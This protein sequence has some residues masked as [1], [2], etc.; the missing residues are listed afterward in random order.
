MTIRRIK[1]A[2]PEMTIVTDVALDRISDGHDGIV[3]EN[4]RILNDETVSFGPQASLK[5]KPVPILLR[6]VT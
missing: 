5:Q 2:C 6:R 1:E 3:D 4:G